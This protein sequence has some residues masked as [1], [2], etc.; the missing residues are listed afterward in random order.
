MNWRVANCPVDSAPSEEEMDI[1][2]FEGPIKERQKSYQVDFNTL[3]KQ[4]VE[5]A[6][7]EDIAYIS[8][9][10]GLEV[11]RMSSLQYRF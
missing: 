8:G 10:F 1:D 2:A 3:S 7:D 4:G 5:N 9:L 11:R 6:M